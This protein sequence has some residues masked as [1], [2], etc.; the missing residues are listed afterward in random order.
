[1]TAS[2][3]SP[4]RPNDYSGMPDADGRFGDYGGR[5]V[6]E[7]LM[8]LVHELEAAYGAARVDP[9]FQRELGPVDEV[10]DP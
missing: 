9:E 4:Q 2:T 1:M 7:T 10:P 8:P 6:P 3:L 5:Y